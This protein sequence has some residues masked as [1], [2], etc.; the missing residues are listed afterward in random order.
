MLRAEWVSGLD[1]ASIREAIKA[2]SF[3]IDDWGPSLALT[4]TL[5]Q[6]LEFQRIDPIEAGI[7]YKHFMN[8]LQRMSRAKRRIRTVPVCEFSEDQ[9]L[10]IH[11]AIEVPST[12]TTT[13]FFYD[14]GFA[15][16]RT[17]WARPKGD[18]REVWS[19]GWSDYMAK[20]R[21]KPDFS[22]CVLW[23]SLHN[24]TT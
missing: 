4:L 22:E 20:R 3:S 21:T 23:E 13:E 18:I 19:R 24:P 1:Q 12:V 6:K 7:N 5:R 15:W 8:R 9:R 14:I 17:K 11:A 10:H 2:H 16:A